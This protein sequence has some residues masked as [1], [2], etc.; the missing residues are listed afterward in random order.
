MSKLALLIACTLF[1]ALVGCGASRP[2][3][4]PA[5]A[6]STVT[7]INQP[8][9]PVCKSTRVMWLATPEGLVKTCGACGAI[10]GIR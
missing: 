1:P 4:T 2:P 6:A 10:L 5:P 3:D 8:P 7:P 9:C